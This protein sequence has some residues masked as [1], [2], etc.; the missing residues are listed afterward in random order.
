[1]KSETKYFLM[2]L[3]LF[4]IGSLLLQ[5]L[6]VPL[7]EIGLSKPDLVLVVVLL[8]GKRFRSVQGSTAGFILGL[9]QDSLTGM[10]IGITAFPKAIAGYA[11][12]KTKA[13][14]MEGTLYYI[15]FV[16][17]IL[18]HEMISFAFFQYKAELPYSLLLYTRVFPNTI[19]TTIMLFIVNF[20]TQ[21]YFT[22]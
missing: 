17:L 11:A 14:R 13:F 5:S 22:E 10:P 7:M 8:I 15:W 18:L 2:I 6:V 21:K 1:M 9:F 3:F 12:G 19:Y 16:F 4:G 20:F